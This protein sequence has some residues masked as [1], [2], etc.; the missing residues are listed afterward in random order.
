MKRIARVL[1]GV[2][3]LF[4]CQSSLA[5]GSITILEIDTQ[6]K[7][8]YFDDVDY[9]KLASDATAVKPVGAPNPNK[10]FSHG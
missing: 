2:P 10:P 4:I 9:S 7:V 6:A 3:Y 8:T 1:L 5:Q